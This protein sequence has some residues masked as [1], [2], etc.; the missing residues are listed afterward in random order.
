MLRRTN[1]VLWTHIPSNMFVT[2]F[3]GIL[4]PESGG[5]VFA[6]AGHTPPCCLSRNGVTD[7]R[8]TGM[9]LV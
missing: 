2:C 4:D 6:N 1:E 3:Y 5:L 9:P 8:A 7:L